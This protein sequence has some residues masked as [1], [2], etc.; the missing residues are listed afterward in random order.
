MNPRIALR[1][2]LAK[3]WA[4]TLALVI[5]NAV[6]SP[7]LLAGSRLPGMVNLL[8]PLVLAAL[9]SVPSILSGGG[10]LDL[11]VGPLLG[12]VNVFAVGVLVPRGLGSA[13]I[14]IP[15]CLL[16][17]AAVG[18]LN[19]AL[20]AYGRLQP[21][22]VTLGSFLV[23]AGL[24]L[25]VMPEPV[26]GAPGWAAF[27]ADS[28]LGGYLPHS[29]ILL[30]AAFGLWAAL[31][32]AGFVRLVRAVGS[33]Q[34]AAYTSGVNVPAIRLGAYTLGGVFAALAGLALTALINSGDPTAGR[35]YTL[36]AIAAVALGANALHGG[37]GGILGPLLGAGTL[38]LIQLLLSAV[39]VSS[40]WIQVVY[41]TVLLVA[42]CLNSTTAG[43]A[44]LRTAAPQGARP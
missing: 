1:S 10:G 22:V 5:A 42:I 13:W 27:L 38:F 26:G 40:L 33:D 12:F 32:T 6:V 37:R 9:A 28:S 35:Q 2:P 36:M 41:G 23:L 29:L 20:V 24:A 21:I 11:S 4:M 25:V 14:G 43:G 8:V 44:R 3:V 16:L 30:L 34:R 39:N 18:A 15:L 17:G 19:G 7:D 31:R